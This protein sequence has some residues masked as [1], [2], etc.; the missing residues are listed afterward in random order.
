[1]TKYTAVTDRLLA[2]KKALQTKLAFSGN[3]LT[4]RDDGKIA[5]FHLDRLAADEAIC[6]LYRRELHALGVE[7]TREE[8]VKARQYWEGLTP[9][10]LF[11]S[12]THQKDQGNELARDDFAGYLVASA[13]E[14][15]FCQ[16][17][18]C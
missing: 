4:Y 18:D 1:M 14:S 11:D 7:Y 15:W 10:E 17:Y 16:A 9:L 13:Y 2:R 6:D 3:Y 12:Y 8:I 5:E